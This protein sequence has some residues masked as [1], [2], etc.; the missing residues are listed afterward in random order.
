MEN[1][2]D[3]ESEY[4]SSVLKAREE[5]LLKI[6]DVHTHRRIGPIV[7]YLHLSLAVGDSL[8]I[9]SVRYG[10]SCLLYRRPRTHI[11]IWMLIRNHV[12][13]GSARLVPHIS[14]PLDKMRLAFPQCSEGPR[15]FGW[16]PTIPLTIMKWIRS[17]E[18]RAARRLHYTKTQNAGFPSVIHNPDTGP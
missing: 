7:T 1:S 13:H 3:G 2:F 16:H 17:C 18:A 9:C 6:K 8:G 12:P 11:P 10:Q 14:T 4:R 5:I 15:R